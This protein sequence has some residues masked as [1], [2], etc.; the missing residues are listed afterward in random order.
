MDNINSHINVEFYYLSNETTPGFVAKTVLEI[1]AKIFLKFFKKL[2]KY[3]YFFI[4]EL[5]L[6]TLLN[7]SIILIVILMLIFFQKTTRAKPGTFR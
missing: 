1:Y 3:S 7:T 5:I 2:G 6:T 4:L